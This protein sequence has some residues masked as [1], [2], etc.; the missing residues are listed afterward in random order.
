MP[1]EIPAS[2]LVG[3]AGWA[4]SSGVRDRFGSGASVLHR[5]A[6][7]LNAVEINS[8]FYRP[9]RR[10]T[11]ERW[12]A[13]VGSAFR[14]SVKVP[15]A[16]THEK[17]L[18]GCRELM[19]RFA[20]DAGGLGGKLGAVLVQ[21]PPSLVFESGIA[22]CFFKMTT[23][24]I[25]APVVCEPRHASWFSQAADAVLMQSG[26]ARVAAHPAVHAGANEPGGSPAIAYFRLHGHPKIYYSNYDPV[27][28]ERYASRLIAQA[29]RGATT[30]C[31]FDNTA[32]GCATDNALQMRHLLARTPTRPA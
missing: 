4:I 5:Y 9:H 19:L 2:T 17:R 8:S 11:Y 16:V 28:L 31:I 26:V 29:G 21:L 27:E 20:D 7:R 22:E 24:L 25:E 3:T 18:I 30:W 23:G 10:T 14:F 1:R 6:T 15:K 12:A 13:S 32:L